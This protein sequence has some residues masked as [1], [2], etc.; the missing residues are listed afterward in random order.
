MYYE[1]AGLQDAD[2]PTVLMS[3]GLGGSGA[4]WA[5]QLAALGDSFRIIL[6]DHAGTGRSRGTLP[7]DYGMGH[8]AE[9]A[10]AL[11]D[12]LAIG[13]CHFIGHALGGMIGL[14]L[15]LAHPERIDRLVVI[16]SWLT[17][18]PHTRRCFD[19]R[20]QILR[21]SGV[22]AYVR[23]Q[24]LFLYPAD[25]LSRHDA[26]LKLEEALQIQHFQGSQNL[27]RRL[28][29]LMDTDFS[30]RLAPLSAPVLVMSCRDDMLVPWQCSRALANALPAAELLEM[31]YGG[32]A[33]SVSNSAQFN[34]LLKAYL[35]RLPAA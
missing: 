22:E 3:A 35:Q 8:M 29:A 15:A 21:D 32:H 17:L 25:W 20:R 19:I 7:G 16:N 9:D 24:P 23:A 34:P 5:P 14:E 2:A 6:Y 11:L 31:S 4:F 27:L 33:M 30:Q 1:T 13:R 12:R 28:R 10:I 18:D 26:L